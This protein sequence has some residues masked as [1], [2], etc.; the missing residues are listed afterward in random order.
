[1]LITRKDCFSVGRSGTDPFQGL[2]EGHSKVA[3]L[4]GEYFEKHDFDLNVFDM[5][6]SN[7]RQVVERIAFL[8]QFYQ[9]KKTKLVQD[10]V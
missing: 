3:T 4:S 2:L 5:S 7:I 9:I 1:M 8:N 6:D 10:R